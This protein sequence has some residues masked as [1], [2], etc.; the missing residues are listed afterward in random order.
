[1]T[2]LTAEK[3]GE[4]HSYLASARPDFSRSMATIRAHGGPWECPAC[5]GVS[6]LIY[7]CSQC[8]KDLARGGA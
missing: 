3:I 7:R 1:M 6:Y 4:T 2:L 5:D 8:G